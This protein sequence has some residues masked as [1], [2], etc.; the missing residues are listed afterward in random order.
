MQ[1]AF[2]LVVCRDLPVHTIICVS[3]VC[4][5]FL[6]VG[7]RIKN[8]FYDAYLVFICLIT[9]KDYNTLLVNGYSIKM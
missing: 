4:I 3:D 9:E 7:F 5:E 8:Y 2:V 1:S 6:H